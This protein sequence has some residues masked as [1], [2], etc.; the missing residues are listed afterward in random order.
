MLTCGVVSVATRFLSL[1]KCIESV[2]FNLN[3]L[4]EYFCRKAVKETQKE[5]SQRAGTQTKVSAVARTLYAKL[6][7]FT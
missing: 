2:V 3:P 1:Q 6:R 7:S 5:A 4:L